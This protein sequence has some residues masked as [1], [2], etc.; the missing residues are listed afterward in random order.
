MLNVK[1][2]ERL[3]RTGS[4]LEHAFSL[5]GTQ[6]L[7][8]LLMPAFAI[9]V[10]ITGWASP[11]DDSKPWVAKDWTAWTSSDCSQIQFNSPWSHTGTAAQGRY[12][13]NSSSII[14][15]SLPVRQAGLRK[16]QLEKHYDKMDAEKKQEFDQQYA[17][18]STVN[19]SD[20]VVIDIM[21][22]SDRPPRN[23]SA[24]IGTYA[25]EAAAQI[26][27]RLGDGTLILPTQITVLN[28]PSGVDVFGNNTEYDFPRTVGGRLLY[29]PSDSFLTIVLGAPL[30]VDKKTKKVEQQDFRVVS[31]NYDSFKI[32]DLMYKGKL[33]Y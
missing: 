13:S 32:S 28:P 18:R 21:N 8:A 19:Y 5:L 26:A 3:A 22:S 7:V 11:V 31:D 4:A 1:L 16:L 25:P 20:L 30:I 27:L 33:E 17:T 14:L 2:S 29:S 9:G 24:E 23:A 6:L 10:V 15:L 12:G